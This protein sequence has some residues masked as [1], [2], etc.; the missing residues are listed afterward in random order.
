M[1]TTIE[2]RVLIGNRD[3]Q[4]QNDSYFNDKYFRVSMLNLLMCYIGMFILLCIHF[5]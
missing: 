2:E 5:H 1:A 4:S 3:E